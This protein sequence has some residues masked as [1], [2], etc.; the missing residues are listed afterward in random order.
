MFT[1]ADSYRASPQAISSCS[2]GVP[3]ASIRPSTNTAPSNHFGAQWADLRSYTRPSNPLIY[4][5]FLDAALKPFQEHNGFTFCILLDFVRAAS[6]LVA[7]A[8]A[9]KDGDSRLRAHFLLRVPI[10]QS[11]VSQTHSSDDGNTPPH[12]Y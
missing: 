2:I 11:I 5:G 6:S 12:A 10:S 9:F 4:A 8:A 7:G 3:G 1:R